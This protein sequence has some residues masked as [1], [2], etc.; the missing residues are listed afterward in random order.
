MAD[1]RGGGKG[2]G[3]A[4][5][6][7]GGQR[8]KEHMKCSCGEPCGC[9]P[10]GCSEGSQGSIGVGKAYCKCGIGCGCVKCAS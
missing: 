7:P 4:V 1:V 10:C 5:P 2:C 8:D 3:C 6:C 9:N